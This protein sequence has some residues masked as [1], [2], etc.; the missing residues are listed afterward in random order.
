MISSILIYLL[1]DIS[2][3]ALALALAHRRDFKDTAQC[4]IGQRHHPVQ[5]E[6][7]GIE[8]QKAQYDQYKTQNG[9]ARH[10]SGDYGCEHI[11]EKPDLK[12]VI[13]SQQTDCN[14]THSNEGVVGEFHDN[15]PKLF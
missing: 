4:Q 8:G 2:H 12:P 10:I 15:T 1:P 14:E 5:V 7:N 3:H 13:V 9:H 11:V 6:K